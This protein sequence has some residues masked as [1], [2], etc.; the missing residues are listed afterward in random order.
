MEHSFTAENGVLRRY[1]GPGGHVT[2]PQG[3]TAV[4]RAAFFRRGDVISAVL[5]D[6][7]ERI[8]G[9]AFAECAAL[10]HITIPE[11]VTELGSWAFCGCAALQG[12]ALPAGLR[13]L[14]A[15]TFWRCAALESIGLPEGLESIGPEAFRQCGALR[16]IVLPPDL[17]TMGEGV[18]ENCASLPAVTLP[19]RLKNVPRRAFR[20]CRSLKSIR[21]SEGVERVEAEAFAGCA[22]LREIAF[23]ASVVYIAPTALEGCTALERIT[24]LSP[25]AGTDYAPEGV[26]LTAP[27][28]SP[29]GSPR[30]MELALGYALARR[31]GTAFP[32]EREAEYTEYLRSHHSLLASLALTGCPGLLEALLDADAIPPEEVDTLLSA[33]STAEKRTALLGY[34]GRR[35]AEAPDAS[36]LWDE[37]DLDLSL[38]PLSGEEAEKAWDYS[39]CEDGVTLTAWKGGEREIYVPARIGDWSVTAIGERAFSPLQPG[40][41]PV[42]RRAREEITG[43]YLPYGVRRIADDAFRNCVSLRELLLPET[44]ESVGSGAF[45]GTPWWGALPEGCVYLGNILYRY[46]GAMPPGAAL[47][48]REGTAAV[49]Q[50]AFRDREELSEIV[51]PDGLESVGPMAFY[52]NV[53]LKAIRLPA[54]LRE[55]GV[56]AF[57][58]CADLSELALPEGC[59]ALGDRAFYGCRG[60]R[61]VRLPGSLVSIGQDAFRRCP[62]VTVRAPAGSAAERFARENRIP[63]AAEGSMTEE[64]ERP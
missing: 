29:A 25:A 46:K 55:I 5:P 8:E 49:A 47:S 37:A 15:R 22:A 33:C 11:S 44:P 58:G 48:L 39:P 26:P 61:D 34:R 53:H 42:Q 20:G 36:D 4:G 6:G 57:H 18:M 14:E 63:F 16:E 62:D 41:G 30:A 3:T 54:S 12:A 51:L 32:P 9:S 38:E 45:L 23:P 2:V 35:E 64:G 28:I 1:A 19:P 52:N 50:G 7:L 60:L 27:G 21:I 17:R 10:E 56:Y 13:R 59:R 43:I 40:L 24:L 31:E